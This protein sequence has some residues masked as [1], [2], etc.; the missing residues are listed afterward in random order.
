MAEQDTA[1]SVAFIEMM[2]LATRRGM[3][4]LE[5]LPACWEVQVD[6]DWWFAVNGGRHTRMCT[7]N[8]AVPP[9]LMYVQY[10]DDTA[11]LVGLQ[12]GQFKDPSLN[13]ESDFIEA[14]KDC[15]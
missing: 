10:K 6:K 3:G 4:M 2:K 11:S 14:L 15:E 8:I 9:C 5:Q 7:K 13:I 12:V 1:L